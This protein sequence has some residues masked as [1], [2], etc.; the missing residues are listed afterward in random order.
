MK[1]KEIRIEIR[2]PTVQYGYT[3]YTYVVEIDRNSE[4]IPNVLRHIASEHAIAVAE[5]RDDA[6]YKE[7]PEPN[8]PIPFE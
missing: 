6:R 2:Q 4:T 1:I 8:E 5:V 7:M 3:D